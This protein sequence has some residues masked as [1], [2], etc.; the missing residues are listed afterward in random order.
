LKTGWVGSEE[1]QV[2]SACVVHTQPNFDWLAADAYLFDIDGTL[3]NSRDAVHYHAFHRAVADVFGLE[4]RFDGIPVH[5]NTDVGILQAYL[6]AAG[7]P[8][9]QWRPRMP[10]VFE[11]MSAEVERNAA[12]FRPELC[13]SIPE[14]IQRLSA[15]GKLLGVASG[16]IERVGWAKLRAAGLRD[17][18]SFGAFSGKREKRDEVI[19][20]GI[21]QARSIRGQDSTIYV[22]GDTPADIRSAHAN[23]IAVIAVATGIYGFD[24]LLSHSPEMCVSCCTD[25]LNPLSSPQRL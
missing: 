12:N 1:T 23:G 16:N 25:L 24:E 3:L 18:F 6:R 17:H 19:A 4:L 7:V 5:G 11:M 14:L 10:K 13:P 8:E 20:H 2:A 21:E 9:D 15:Q 22:V